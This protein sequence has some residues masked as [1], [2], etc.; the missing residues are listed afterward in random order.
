MRN[1]ILWRQA[2][3]AAHKDHFPAIFDTDQKELFRFVNLPK[4]THRP[5]FF[6][7]SW[8]FFDEGWPN[9]FSSALVHRRHLLPSRPASTS[10][11][12]ETCF[13][14]CVPKE[15]TEC[16]SFSCTTHVCECFRPF[17]PRLCSRHRCLSHMRPASV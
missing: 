1:Y 16:L 7:P 5:L 15:T 17:A 6:R 9:R 4:K 2:Q 8:K 3:T 12:A 13:T 14:T 11:D 10:K